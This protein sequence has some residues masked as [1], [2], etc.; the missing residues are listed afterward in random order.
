MRIYVVQYD[1]EYMT[2]HPRRYR[3]AGLSNDVEYSFAIA[4]TKRKDIYKCQAKALRHLTD[5]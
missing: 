5:I 3:P 2:V 4:V 1:M